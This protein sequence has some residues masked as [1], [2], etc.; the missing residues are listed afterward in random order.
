MADMVL[1]ATA[2]KNTTVSPKQWNEFLDE[3]CP[4]PHKPPTTTAEWQFVPE[5]E[6]IDRKTK[7]EK[8]ENIAR[9]MKFAESEVYFLLLIM[10]K[11]KS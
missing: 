5:Y 3:N 8:I 6:R 11:A 1:E 10:I 2:T 7:L 4:P 9:C